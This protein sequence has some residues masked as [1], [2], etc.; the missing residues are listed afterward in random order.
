MMRINWPNSQITYKHL[1]HIPQCTIQNRNVH[2]SVLNGALWDMAQVYYGICE[3][4][5][6]YGDALDRLHDATNLSQNNWNTFRDV[7]HLQM[8]IFIKIHES[9]NY[10]ESLLLLCFRWNIG[11]NKKMSKSKVI[12]FEIRKFYWHYSDRGKYYW[13][14]TRKNTI[15][16]NTQQ[17]LTNVFVS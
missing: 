8:T 3:I 13:C 6:L 7:T 12:R 2:I 10:F 16:R 14:N 11:L 1:L 17:R 9:D 4:S 15:Q 5:L